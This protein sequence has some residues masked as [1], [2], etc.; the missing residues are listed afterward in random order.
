[1]VDIFWG[2]DGGFS[3]Q[4]YNINWRELR[5]YLLP[6]I[7]FYFEVLSSRNI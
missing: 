3:G 2:L 7:L 4:I 6:S 5:I 1:M